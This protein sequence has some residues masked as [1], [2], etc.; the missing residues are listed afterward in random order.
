MCVVAVSSAEAQLANLIPGVRARIRAPGSV[1]GRL[2]GTVVARTADSLSIATENG[3]PVQ[4]PLSMLT[5]V[6]ISQGKSRSKGAMKGALWGGGVGI[7]SGLF[8]DSSTD[9]D[10]SRGEVIAA[11]VLAGAMTGALIGA[12]VQSESWQRLEVPVRTALI[13]THGGPTAVVSIRF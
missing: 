8:S 1:Q 11:G 4:L 5:A 13:R 12:F 9:A 3:V 7:L 2:T 10:V 6:E